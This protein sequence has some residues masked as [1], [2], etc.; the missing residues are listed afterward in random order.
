MASF[1]LKA[2]L[3]KCIQ[4]VWHAAVF[5][6]LY[7]CGRGSFGPTRL[8]AHVVVLLSDKNTQRDIP[9]NVL[10]PR[11]GSIMGIIS[12]MCCGEKKEEKH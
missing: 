5:A 12:N 10:G 2:G 11:A 1:V 8:L 9:K 7:L 6:W 3:S 4:R